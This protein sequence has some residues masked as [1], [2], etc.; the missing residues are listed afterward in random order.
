MAVVESPAPKPSVPIPAPPAPASSRTSDTGRWSRWL[1]SARGRSQAMRP[2]IG[3]RT[4][5]RMTRED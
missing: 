2:T 3:D 1:L 5:G 4:A